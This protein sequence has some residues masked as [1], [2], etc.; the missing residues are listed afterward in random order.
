MQIV[1]NWVL[2]GKRYFYLL[3][4]VDNTGISTFHGPVK[5]VPR[6]VYGIGK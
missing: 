6:K 3:E 2:N 5:A 1:D 4:D